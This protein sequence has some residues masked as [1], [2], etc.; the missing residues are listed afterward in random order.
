M[1]RKQTF[2]CRPNQAST[3][4]KLSEK[5][6]K[7]FCAK[8]TTGYDILTGNQIQVTIDTFETWQ[9]ADNALTLY[10]LTNKKTITNNETYALAPDTFQ[11]IVD[12]REKNV[13]TLK[14]IFDIIYKE[15]FSKLSTSS[16]A[17]YRS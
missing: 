11:K 1:A 2:R 14:E 16:A 15:D 8:V 17:G 10:R 13:P 6:R 4:V 12:Q 9:E 5:R 3:V 7:P